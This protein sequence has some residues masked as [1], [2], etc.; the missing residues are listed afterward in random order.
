[1]VSVFRYIFEEKEGKG[2]SAKAGAN[3]K[4]SSTKKGPKQ[5]IIA[6]LQVSLSI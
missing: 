1:M 4:G 2:S 3:A 6:R 5:A